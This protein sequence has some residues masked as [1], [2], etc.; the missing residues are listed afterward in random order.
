MRLVEGS[1]SKRRA[2]CAPPLIADVR[3]RQRD[4]VTRFAT[5]DPTQADAAALV[6]HL[7]SRPWKELLELPPHKPDAVKSNRGGTVSIWRDLLPD[8]RVRVV[9]Q[10]HVPGPLGSAKVVA[11]G[12][13]V[14]MSG[15]VSELRD[16]ELWDFT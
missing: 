11:D 1:S 12:F 5:D 3:P 8:E 16:E 7:R 2:D 14:S 9:V 6:Q 15:E 10:T 13:V 4:V